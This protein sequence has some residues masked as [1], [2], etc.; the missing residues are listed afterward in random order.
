LYRFTALLITA[1]DFEGGDPMSVRIIIPLLFAA[2]LVFLSTASFAQVGV[3][4]R[5]GPPPLPVYEQPICPGT[6]V[7][8]LFWQLIKSQRVRF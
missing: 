7:Q 2:G 3:S 8:S 1:G 6:E 5:I 4:I